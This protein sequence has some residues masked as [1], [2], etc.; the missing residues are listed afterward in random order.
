MKEISRRAMI[1]GTAGAAL[2]TVGGALALPA[3]AA[4]IGEPGIASVNT[5]G[6]AAARGSISII[7]GRPDKIL[8]HH[9][10]T[11]NTTNHSRS[12]AYALARSIQQ[13]HFNNG[14]SDS[15]QHFT[16][17]RGGI[18]MAG[19]HGALGAARNGR[20]L[21]IG[22]HCPGQNEQLGIENEGNYTNNNIR[23]DHYRKLVRLCAWLCQQYGINPSR[24]YGHRDFFATACPGNKL[25]AKLPQLRRDVRA[26]L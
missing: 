21:V 5:W 9:T 17:S 2:L 14:W 19:R 24:L 23:S 25:Y 1:G 22:A 11:P 6:A 18:I 3:D 4:G 20:K 7:S 26:L 13:G 8:I 16:V 10:D 15:G 12:H